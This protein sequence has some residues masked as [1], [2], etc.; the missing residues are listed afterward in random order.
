VSSPEFFEFCKGYRWNLGMFEG[1]CAGSQHVHAKKIFVEAEEL[2]CKSLDGLNYLRE[3]LLSFNTGRSC[4]LL[5]SVMDKFEDL[6]PPPRTSRPKKG[7]PQLL[8][9][10]WQGI[11]LLHSP[12]LA[13]NFVPS[14]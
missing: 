4:I 5:P 9:P 11:I 6:P 13:G 12:P 2:L 1:F 14:K 3:E 7:V 8:S 10:Y